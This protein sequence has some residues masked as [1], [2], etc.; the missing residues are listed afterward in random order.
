MGWLSAGERGGRGYVPIRNEDKPLPRAGEGGGFGREKTKFAKP[1]TPR[2]LVGF[3]L[4]GDLYALVYVCH[5]YS[6]VNQLYKA[7]EYVIDKELDIVHEWEVTDQ[8]REEWETYSRA[9]VGHTVMRH[10]LQTRARLEDFGDG[11]DAFK[12]GV[13]ELSEGESAETF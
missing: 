9:L 5:I 12:L 6:H 11:D 10:T 2:G 13:R 3:T 1:P 7:L 8:Q 4:S